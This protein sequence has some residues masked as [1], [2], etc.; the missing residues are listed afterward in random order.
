MA[1]FETTFTIIDSFIS[2]QTKKYGNKYHTSLISYIL[3]VI[4]NG[5]NRPIDFT[6][7]S[8]SITDFKADNCFWTYYSKMI[9]EHKHRGDTRW[10]SLPDFNLISDIIAIGLRW[11]QIFC[12]L[13]IYSFWSVRMLC[14]RYG[15]QIIS[16]YFIW[17]TK[18]MILYHIN[19]V[20]FHI[21]KLAKMN[22]RK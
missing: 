1:M 15:I 3:N 12:F 11:Y 16:N 2:F 20:I 9:N 5:N 7:G 13:Y 19:D 17:R 22:Q 18:L 4:T 14:A 8:I 10:F 21:C 6:F